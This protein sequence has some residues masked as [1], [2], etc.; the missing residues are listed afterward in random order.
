VEFIDR[1]FGIYFARARR[2]LADAP[3]T[4]AWQRAFHQ[5]TGWFVFPVIAAGGLA[6]EL[7][8]LLLDTGHPFVRKG[9]WQIAGAIAFVAVYVVLYRRYR[10]YASLQPGLTPGAESDSDKQALRWFRTFTLGSCVLTLLVILAA[11]L[12]GH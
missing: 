9:P 2:Q 11:S 1:V 6:M 8:R 12:S 5:F 3:L 10:G 7:K 4:A